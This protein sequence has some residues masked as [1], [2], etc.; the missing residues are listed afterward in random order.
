[1]TSKADKPD[2]VW[3]ARVT[4]QAG[5]R[6]SVYVRRHRFD[7]GEPLEFDAES[8]SVSALEY[9][10][11]ALGADV[12][13][14]LRRAARRRRLHL[15]RA[16]ATVE[17]RLDNPLVHLGVVGEEGHPGIEEVRVKVYA[18]SLDSDEAVRDAWAEALERSPLVRTLRGAVEL[19]L[20][21]NV[22]V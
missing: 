11:G 9:A 8:D 1:M 2:F 18:S 4:A 19:S 3:T 5:D 16:E 13:N 20:E 15:D 7:V 10:L 6:A 21:L 22:V 17:G 12:L 14:G